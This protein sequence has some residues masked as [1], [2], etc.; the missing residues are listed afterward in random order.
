MA[1]R[2]RSR[3]QLVLAVLVPVALVLG[4]WLGGHPTSLPGFARDAL[5][6][7]K[8]TRVV[9]EAIDRIHDTYY[10]DVPRSRLADQAIAGMVAQLHDR[11]S[12]YFDPA[13]YRSF[14]MVESSEFSGVGMSVIRSAQGL[15]VAQVFDGSPARRAGIR[16][17]DVVVAANGRSLRGR[18]A[19]QAVALIKGPPGTDVRLTYV[20]NGRRTTVTVT[21]AT[22]SVPVVASRVRRLDGLK[23]GILALSQFSSGAHGEVDAALRRLMARG[24]RGLVFDLRG[25]GGGFVKEAQL[26]ASAFLRGGPIVTTRGRSVPSRTLDA[27]DNPIAPRLPLVVLVDRNTA[28][29]SEIVAGALQDRHRALLVGE[30]TFGKGV[31]QEVIN[32]TNG[33]ALDIT[34]GQY[35]T[36][37]GRNLGGG[38]VRK[39]KGLTPDVRVVDN[40]N[41]RRDEAL[42]RALRALAARVRR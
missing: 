14:R 25:N 4:I 28:S 37:K 32:L 24:I 39:G 16:A 31:F 29:A 38:G 11:F 15:R 12:H 7:D 42:S 9:R 21:R 18:S 5:V 34:A 33:G 41:T 2:R 6:G 8:D 13:E 22:V 10:R 36:P 40:P 20:R 3:R 19:D 26:I 23:L 17:G 35:F 27:G 30:P 1:P